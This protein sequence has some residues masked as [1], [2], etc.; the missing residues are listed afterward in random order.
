MPTAARSLRPAPLLVLVAVIV[1]AGGSA[2]PRGVAAATDRL[3]T[4]E[5]PRVLSDAPDR[6]DR[7]GR[8]RHRPRGARRGG[9]DRTLDAR[10]PRARSEVD[11]ASRGRGFRGGARGPQ[12]PLDPGPGD[13]SI[14]Q[15]LR[16]LVVGLS[17]R[18]GLPLGLRRCTERVPVRPRPQRVQATPRRVRPWPP[19]KGHGAALRRR[20]RH[21]PYLCR[22][23]VAGHDARGRRVGLC[24]PVDPEPDPADLRGGGQRV[25]PHR[26]P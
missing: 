2:G 15:R 5:R 26:P 13:R 10:R 1:L 18:S 22:S 20:T 7:S 8:R 17:R 11:V 6:I 14:G 4:D 19:G 24:R 25:P 9:L 3:P 16:V 12:P 23:L 21:R